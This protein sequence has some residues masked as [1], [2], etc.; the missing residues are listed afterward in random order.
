MRLQS[1][2]ELREKR[3]DGSTQNRELSKHLGDLEK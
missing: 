1:P 3:A 2:F